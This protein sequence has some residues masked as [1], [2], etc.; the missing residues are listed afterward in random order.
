MIK[1]VQ[2]ERTIELLPG[3]TVTV[4]PVT[5]TLILAL[6]GPGADGQRGELE[7]VRAIARATIVAW[8][9]VEDD[10]GPVEP[11]PDR[12]DAFIDVWPVYQ[13]FVE[14]VVRPAFERR[15]AVEEEKK[16]YTSSHSG[17]GEG[18]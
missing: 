14:H 18:A 6:T 3:V 4:R 15:K 17:G 16:D 9:G 12:I 5:T 7:I 11:T 1:L 10:T 2:R 8:S 13:A